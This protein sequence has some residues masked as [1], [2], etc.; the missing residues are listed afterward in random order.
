MTSNPEFRARIADVKEAW[1]RM[2][3]IPPSTNPEYVKAEADLRNASAAARAVRLGI[4]TEEAMRQITSLAAANGGVDP[5]R[6]EAG[7]H[8]VEEGKS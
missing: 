5:R 4:D 1:E 8:D 2:N 3:S 6:I 7:D